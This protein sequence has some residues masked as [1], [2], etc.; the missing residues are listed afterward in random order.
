LIHGEHKKVKAS[1]PIFL[2]LLCAGTLLI[3]C[4][5]LLVPFQEDIIFEDEILSVLCML[6]VWFLSI[7]VTVAF[8]ALFAKT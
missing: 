1:Q 3:G 2:V 7:G 4:S 6:Q 8:A 5:T